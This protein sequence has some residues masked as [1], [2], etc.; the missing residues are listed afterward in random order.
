MAR[1]N[2]KDVKS[3][4]LPLY[5][6][7]KSF[8]LTGKGHL[9]AKRVWDKYADLEV[10]VN[11]P[12]DSALPGIILAVINDGD[13]SGVYYVKAIKNINGDETIIE[14]LSDGDSIILDNTHTASEALSS[15]LEDTIYFT[16]DNNSIVY[17]QKEYGNPDL[18][19]YATQQWVIEQGYLKAARE[20]FIEEVQVN[21]EAL[22]VFKSD[23]KNAVNIVLP[24][25]AVTN[26]KPGEKILSL[27]N[28]LL[29]SDLSLDFDNKTN[30]LVLYGKTIEGVKQVVSTLDASAFVVDGML[31][32]GSLG[33]F[34]HST[35]NG[36]VI[37]TPTTENAPGATLCLL[38]VLNTDGGEREICIPVSSLIKVYKGTDGQIIVNPSTGVIGLANVSKNNTTASG[39]V[40]KHGDSFTAV[41]NI[42]SDNYGRVTSTVN[43]QITLPSVVDGEKSGQ[44]DHVI[45][46]VKTSEGAVTEVTVETDD[47]ASAKKLDG[48]EIVTSAALNDLNRRIENMYDSTTQ[49]ITSEGGSIYVENDEGVAKIELLWS[50]WE[51]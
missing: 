49:K 29:S 10:Y 16:T 22:E 27:E 43:Q 14:K 48:F 41:T 36:Q 45:V 33:W 28:D 39:R 5:G 35:V 32:S 11:D 34:T 6:W 30:T 47:I 38:L 24:E 40:L 46:T 8:D 26:I 31:Q 23:N 3:P 19:D 25:S 37:H 15:E 50:S 2:D 21:G 20:D 17:K 42:T 51:E 13:N 4:A 12:N 7:G 9:I 44:D 1:R 18:S